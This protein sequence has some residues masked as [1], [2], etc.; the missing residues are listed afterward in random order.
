MTPTHLLLATDGSESSLEAARLVRDLL[1]PAA[2]ARV[3]ILAV[4]PPLDTV[5]FYGANVGYGMYGGGMLSPE[6]YDAATAL[7]EQTAQNAMRRTVEELNTTTPAESVVRRGSPV[8]EIVR[9]AGEHG[10][11]LIVMGSRGWGE[12]HAVLLGSVSERVLHTAPCP[13]LIARPVV[14]RTT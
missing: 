6:T 2:L 8:D 12:M 9:Y 10:V 11:G 4:V 7:A 14:T 3:T 1:N 13:V 5:P